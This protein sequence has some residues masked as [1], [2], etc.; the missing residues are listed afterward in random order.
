V[1]PHR[2]AFEHVVLSAAQ[3]AVYPARATVCIVRMI[4]VCP[5]L[6]RQK[7]CRRV[8]GVCPE[9]FIDCG[10]R[11]QNGKLEAWQCG[12]TAETSTCDLVLH[13]V[14]GSIQ[15]CALTW[16]AAASKRI[17]CSTLAESMQRQPV[18]ACK[19]AAAHVSKAAQARIAGLTRNHCMVRCWLSC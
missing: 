1:A 5:V 19:A 4:R 13:A 16:Q 10:A 3:S 8:L 12:F 17:E 14:L 2:D 9:C 7:R 18:P 11:Y 15:G 6:S